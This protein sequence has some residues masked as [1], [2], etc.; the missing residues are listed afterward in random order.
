MGVLRHHIALAVSNILFGISFSVYVSL[1]QGVISQSQLFVLQLLFPMF[2]FT[3]LAMSHRGFFRLSLD[4]FGSIFIVALL[5]V[6][7]WWYLLM[8]GASYTNPIDASTIATI[9]PIFTLMTSF[10]VQSRRATKGEILGIIVAIVGVVAIL[11]DRGRMLLG[12]VGEAYGNA[13]VLCAVVAIAVN[14]VLITPVLRRCGTVVVMGWYYLIGTV[15]SM[16]LIVAELPT[17][18]ISDFT[19]SQLAEMGYILLFGSALPM[20]LLYKSSEHLTAMHNAI[21]R[22]IQPI[23]AT[24]VAVSR[25]QTIIDRTNI[26]GAVLIF[27]GMLCVIL[28]T[29]RREITHG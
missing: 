22:Y 14:T 9:G 15:L 3:P 10:I 1:L 27:L 11:V 25:G 24:I 8:K 4:D 13:L 29:P 12:E 21:Y 2:I 5:V 17:I 26:V 6:F 20:Y 28:S 23:V 16:P 18:S 7:G 19:H